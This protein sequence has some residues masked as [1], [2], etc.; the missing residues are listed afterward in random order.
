[1]LEESMYAILIIFFFVRV[2]KHYKAYEVLS[3][4]LN[5][6]C[7]FF[8]IQQRRHFIGDTSFFCGLEFR[9]KQGRALKLKLFL[10][11]NKYSAMS[12]LARTNFF[13]QIRSGHAGI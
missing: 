7:L 6:T 10:K 11:K 1:M 2:P 5:P 9:Q 4:V 8:F 13:L 12:N 3:N